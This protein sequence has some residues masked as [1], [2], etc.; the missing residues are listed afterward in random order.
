MSPSST[1]P[2]PAEGAPY[3]SAAVLG[4]SLRDLRV[5]EALAARQL[6]LC[7]KPDDERWEDTELDVR[8]TVL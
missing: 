4:L 7:P 2:A 1:T 5:W 6:V 8:R 3:A